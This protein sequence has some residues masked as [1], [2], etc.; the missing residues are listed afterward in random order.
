MFKLF[1]LRLTLALS[2]FLLSTSIHAQSN[3]PDSAFLK[4]IE[5][6]PGERL[7]VHF[8]KAHYLPGEEVWFKA[9]VLSG[10][11]PSVRSTNFY[12]ELYT[13]DGK[14]IEIKAFPVFGASAFGSFSLPAKLT[15]G[16][17]LF[18]SYTSAMAAQKGE[19]ENI[20]RIHI[21]SP[22]SKV[23]Q[24]TSTTSKLTFY[25]EG[26]WLINNL[27]TVLAFRATNENGF[28]VTAKGAI[29]GSDN[30]PVQEF[31]SF[32]NGMGKIYFTP[33]ANEKYYANWKDQAGKEYKTELPALSAEGIALQVLN[34][35]DTVFYTLTRTENL[36]A[37]QQ[38]LH[39]VA[40][41]NNEVYYSADLAFKT[42]TRIRA[43]IPMED[44]PAGM[45]QILVF[46]SDWQP[47]AERITLINKPESSPL[48]INTKQVDLS[49]RGKNLITIKTTDTSFYNLSV[50]VMDAALYNSAA[51]SDINTAMLLTEHLNEYVYNPAFYLGDSDSAKTALDLLLLTH[52]WKKYNWSQI[53]NGEIKQPLYPSFITITAGVHQKL[54]DAADTISVLLKAPTGQQ[55]IDMVKKDGKFI[56]PGL[57]F[58][59][60]VSVLVDPNQLGL[61]KQTDIVFGSELMKGLPVAS[62]SNP[63]PDFIQNDPV[64][65]AQLLQYADLYNKLKQSNDKTLLANVTVSASK[66][67]HM[68]QMDEKYSKG[69]FRG[70]DAYTFDV[71]NDPRGQTAG[72]AF[73]IIR[74]RL[75][76]MNIFRSEENPGNYTAE[77]R[78]NPV[79]FYIDEVPADEYRIND[80]NPADIAYIKVFRPPFF[81]PFSMDAGGAIVVYTK[82]GTEKKSFEPGKLFSTTIKGYSTSRTYSAPDYSTPEMKSAPL[83]DVRT[84]LYWNPFI[85]LSK[86]KP[87]IEIEFFNND[88]ADS[89]VV[90][91]EGITEEGKLIKFEQIVKGK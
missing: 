57:I 75:P 49:K 85:V 21:L 5:Q 24:T 54:Q 3:Q 41:L 43:A 53:A 87:E 52:S 34:K 28:P 60:S 81:A 22:G 72:T 80:L 69:I 61:R 26:G 77:W 39:I 27:P 83:Y 71:L 12:A 50:S 68:D 66:K 35:K 15:A 8:D 17:V 18:K 82:N 16:S 58:Y 25:P 37:N 48:E 73:D 55:L 46:S 10:N 20:Q 7:Y 51:K 6:N 42:R 31:E 56:A 23:V 36:P 33:L 9:Y 84:T 59:D 65:L 4:Y 40:L 13:A 14:L 1:F 88:N 2:A 67:S 74:G 91:V 47:L 30:Q 62:I 38:N 32:H 76:G 64:A 90:I 89:Y 86:D 44:S 19:K 79:A 70:G 29:Y 11:Q 78:G 45:M 63:P